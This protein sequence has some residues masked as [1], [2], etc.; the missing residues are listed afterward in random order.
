MVRASKMRSP[1]VVFRPQSR[2]RAH[3]C[4]RYRRLDLS[5][6]RRRRRRTPLVICELRSL[7]PSM[8]GWWRDFLG[9]CSIAL[10]LAGCG[11]SAGSSSGS[12]HTR[13][14]SSGS[15]AACL[16][17]LGLHAV[18]GGPPAHNNESA[19]PSNLR[20]VAQATAIDEL[21]VYVAAPNGGEPPDT[22]I[23]VFPNPQAASA[24]AAKGGGSGY[25]VIAASNIAWTEG[26]VDPARIGNDIRQCTH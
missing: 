11:G 8:R 21:Y 15:L 24:V 26:T 6:E 1:R 12:S 16:D 3:R 4:D 18:D 5:L 10:V 17:Q 2:R 14:V 9:G 7:G 23:E 20:R 22:T 19:A 13:P 25:T